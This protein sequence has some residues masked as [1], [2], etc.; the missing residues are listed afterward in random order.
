M[1]DIQ[2][3]TKHHRKE[4][5]VLFADSSLR[6]KKLYPTPSE[7]AVHFVEPFKFVCGVEVTDAVVPKTMYNV[8]NHANTVTFVKDGVASRVEVDPQDYLFETL[9]AALYE[10]LD[11]LNIDVVARPDGRYVFKSKQAFG[12]DVGTSTMREILGFDELLHDSSPYYEHLDNIAQAKFEVM[13]DTI[14]DFGTNVRTFNIEMFEYMRQKFTVNENS[15]ISFIH[16]SVSLSV[17]VYED[18]VKVATKVMTNSDVFIPV[19]KGKQYEIV[20][21]NPYSDDA[22]FPGSTSITFV[23]KMRL[24]D[25]EF[26]L[27]TPGVVNMTGERFVRVRCPEIEEYM[28]RSVVCSSGIALVKL[29]DNND[30]KPIKTQT[31]FPIGK[32]NR[33]TFR[34]ER[35]D[36]G[37]YD[38]KGVNNTLVVVVRYMVPFTDLA[39]QSELN[40][41]YSPDVVITRYSEP[42]PEPVVEQDEDDIFFDQRYDDISDAYGSMSEISFDSLE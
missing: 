12:I 35:R 25:G 22:L 41:N 16:T 29:G 20:W 38:F 28:N 26:R 36:G 4:E 5:F 39:F 24:C 31:F 34:F 11:A 3:L 30:F 37:L 27:T 1:D 14:M 32:L 42:S 40:P 8:D 6:N 17:D 10:K 9:R 7:Y 21:V 15:I 33:L 18:N 13:Y 23:E 2:F 19:T